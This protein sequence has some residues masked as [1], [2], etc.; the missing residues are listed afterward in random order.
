MQARRIQLVLFEM[1]E[2]LRIKRSVYH[3]KRLGQRMLCSWFPTEPGGLDQAT[4][5]NLLL[6]EG[7]LNQEVV[8]S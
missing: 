1:Q 5:T 8:V 7:I 4:E 2:M 6:E 3:D